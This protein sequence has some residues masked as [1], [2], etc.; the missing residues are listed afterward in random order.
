MHECNNGALAAASESGCYRK[1]STQD[2]LWSSAPQV[3]VPHPETSPL[4]KPVADFQ[5]V[6]GL[7][8][9]RKPDVLALIAGCSTLLHAD[10]VTV[11]CPACII[12]WEAVVHC[13]GN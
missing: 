7:P 13:N 5:S 10:F 11:Q 12:L 1:N 9:V 8:Q 4:C 6:M 2:V 3:D